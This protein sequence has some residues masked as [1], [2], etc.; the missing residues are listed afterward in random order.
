MKLISLTQ[1]YSAMVDDEDYK[2][3]RE[4]KWRIDK[5]ANTNYAARKNGKQTTYYMHRQNNNILV[6]SQKLTG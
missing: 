6:N 2:Y 3:L 1:G 4:Y 5:Q